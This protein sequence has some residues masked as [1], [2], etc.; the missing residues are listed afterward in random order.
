MQINAHG[1]VRNRL[2]H[3]DA[4]DFALGAVDEVN[5]PEWYGSMASKRFNEIEVGQN[6]AAIRETIGGSELR[7]FGNIFRS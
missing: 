2:H 1:T 4:N 6:V 5:R 7:G 3:A